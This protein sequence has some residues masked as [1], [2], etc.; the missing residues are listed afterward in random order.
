MKMRLFLLPIISTALLFFPV[1]V[2]AGKPSGTPLIPYSICID[3]GHGGTDS[4]AVNGALNENQ[5]N[6]DTANLLKDKLEASN[7]GYTVFMTRTDT[8]TTMS[9]ADRYNYCNSQNAAILISI[10]HNGSTDSTIDYTTALYMKSSDVALA[11]GVSDS[12]S[13]TLG[14]TKHPIYRYASGVLIKAKMPAVISEGFFLTNKDEPSLIA[15]SRLDDEAGAF[16][17]AINTYFGK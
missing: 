3:A 9:N 15:N 13:T 12:I 1:T 2:N 7:K 5:V 16:L 8:T 4:G 11:N 6:L 17:S 10:H 14:L